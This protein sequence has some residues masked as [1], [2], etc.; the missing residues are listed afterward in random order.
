MEMQGDGKS[1]AT[2]AACGDLAVAMQLSAQLASCLASVLL[3]VP[4][5]YLGRE[6]LDRR[7]AFWATV[8]F[9]CLPAT[10]KMMADGL[11]EP[12]FLVCVST[13][14]LFAARGLRTG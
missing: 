11:L 4:M 9:Q 1:A 13:A 3:V 7:T 10:G 5:F 6:L 14:L 2:T 12:V 8:L